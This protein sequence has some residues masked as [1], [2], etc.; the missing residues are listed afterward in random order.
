MRALLHLEQGSHTGSR[1]LKRRREAVGQVKE[2]NSDKLRFENYN[3]FCWKKREGGWKKI[4]KEYE[5]GC[6]CGVYARNCGWYVSIVDVLRN[7][8]PWVVYLPS[9]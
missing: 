1:E 4:G 6:E 8:S 7:K 9:V 2:E 3:L 5:C